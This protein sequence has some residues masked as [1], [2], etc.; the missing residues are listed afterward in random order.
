MDFKKFI[1]DNKKILIIIGLIIIVVIIWRYLIQRHSI[2][3]DLRLESDLTTTTI[4]TGHMCL[5]PAVQQKIADDS[6]IRQEH[7]CF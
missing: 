6:L 1:S 3:S 7:L 5:D 4:S 2:L